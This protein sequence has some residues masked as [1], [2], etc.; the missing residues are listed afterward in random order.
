MA[1]HSSLRG[2]AGGNRKQISGPWGRLRSIDHLYLRSDAVQKLLETTSSVVSRIRKYGDRKLGEQNTKA[3]LVEPI[4]EALGWDIR[5]PDE[6]HREFRP[7]GRD[8]PVD[9]ALKLLRKP[10]MFVEAKGLGETLSERRWIGQV[11]GYAAVAGVEWC[12]LTDGDEYRFY[13]ATAP[14]DAEEKMFCRIRLTEAKPDDAVRALNLMSRANLEENCLDLLWV[15]HFVDRRVKSALRDMLSS[16]DKDLVSL[17]QK[18]VPKT[19]PNE[20]AES[21]SRLDIRVES[22]VIPDIRQGKAPRGVVTSRRSPSGKGAPTKEAINVTLNDLIQSGLLK[23]KDRLFRCYKGHDIEA[24]VG[25]DGSVLYKGHSY[26]SCSKAAEAARSELM[27]RKMTTNGWIFWQ[28]TDGDSR[29]R[30][31]DTLRQAYLARK[32]ASKGTVPALRLATTPNA[33]RSA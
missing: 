20:I 28:Y 4:L 26:P 11:L 18:R 17:I 32:P 22:A 8:N 10:R 16:P 7:K 19:T 31:L 9:Y 24:T 21:I 1:V 29:R 33:I 12:V 27:G 14:I 3:S 15:S 5:D 30:Q 23:P 25:A 2:V 13:N 6:V